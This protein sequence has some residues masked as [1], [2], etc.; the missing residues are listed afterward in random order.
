MKSG[1]TLKIRHVKH[2]PT[3]ALTCSCGAK[4]P[5]AAK[6]RGHIA[7]FQPEQ[8]AVGFAPRTRDFH[9]KKKKRRV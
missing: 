6:L 9:Q 7:L 1:S 4:F 2:E 3:G 8:Q 5:K